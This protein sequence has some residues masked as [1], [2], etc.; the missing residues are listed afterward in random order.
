MTDT[1]VCNPF[2]VGTSYALRD[3]IINNTASPITVNWTKSSDLLLTGVSGLYVCDKLTCYPYGPSVSGSFYM[4]PGDIEVIYVEMKAT[5]G[6]VL[7][8]SYVTIT[9]N[10]GDMVFKFVTDP[11]T[12]NAGFYMY[13]DTL[14]AP[15]TY[16]GINTCAG[17]NLT[18]DWSWDDGTPNS[19][20]PTPSHTYAA[21][22]IYNICVAI[23]DPLNCT[24]TFC[25]NE[26]INKVLSP[27]YSIT[28]SNPTAVADKQIN[29]LS[30]YPNPASNSLYI[31]GKDKMLYRIETFSLYG[32]KVHTDL[33]KG[34]EAMNIT[35]L[36]TGIYL[37]KITDTKGDYQYLKFRK[38]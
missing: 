8:D 7:G 19:S 22:G 3:T 23:S 16:I 37:L 10:Y 20:G 24:D 5:T 34:N 13:E 9:T 32:N 2:P 14:A 15:H 12:C 18:Y 21:A 6:A 26:N 27:W 33:V 25:S 31:K 4:N 11:V 28:F 29:K 1:V 35:A 38:Q 36:S 17:N 30:V